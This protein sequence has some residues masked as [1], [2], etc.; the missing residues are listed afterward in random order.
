MENIEKELEKLICYAMDKEVI[1]PADVEAITTEQISNK[2]FEMVDAIASHNQRH[3][4]DLYYDL[5][6]LK[7]IYNIYKK[8]I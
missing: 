8:N 7:G 3:A 2:V 1:E 4:M 5:L 6:T